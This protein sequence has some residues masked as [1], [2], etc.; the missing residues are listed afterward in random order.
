[1]LRAGMCRAGPEQMLA[2]GSFA[3]A[4]EPV[5]SVWR[6]TALC[7]HAEALL[8]TG[9]VDQAAAVF[10]EASTLAATMA[11]TDSLVDSEAELAMLAM[12]RG[13]WA[14]AAE[15]LERA[16]GPSM[17]IGCMTTPRAGS[18]SPAR[19]VSLCTEATSTKPNAS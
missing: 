2:D 1:M 11:N 3:A 5:S 18:P 6:D 9:D 17:S 8:L 16:L 10:A 19:P 12:N 14:E 13:Q 4:Q 7:M 15:H